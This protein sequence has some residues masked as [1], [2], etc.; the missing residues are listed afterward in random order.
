MSTSVVYGRWRRSSFIRYLSSLT[1]SALCPTFSS[2]VASS[3]RAPP[4]SSVCCCGRYARAACCRRV[5]RT[6]SRSSTQDSWTTWRRRVGRRCC[7][8]RQQQDSHSVMDGRS[9]AA[10]LCCPRPHLSPSYSRCSSSPRPKSD[11]VF[12]L[13]VGKGWEGGLKP[14]PTF[15]NPPTHC[16][17][18][19]WGG[20]SAIYTYDLDHNFG[21]TLAVAK[22]NPQVIFDISHTGLISIETT[23][24]RIRWPPF[25]I[26]S[27]YHSALRLISV[28]PFIQRERGLIKKVGGAKVAFFSD[29][30]CKFSTEEITGAAQYSILAPNSCNREDFQPKNFIFLE[31]NV[32]TKKVDKL[33]FMGEAI[34]TY[35]PPRRYWPFLQAQRWKWVSESWVMGQM[36]RHF[37]MGYIGHERWPIS[38]SA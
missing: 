7:S 22:F 4:S 27:F 33:I 37:W 25:A 23:I 21:R 2:S 36:G 19:N 5:A 31:E 13:P 9:H 32:P 24:D 16:Q 11:T 38:I 8:Q 3:S 1:S 6:S 18:M 15:F 10:K 12:E 35:S 20:G 17:F 29:R 14:S 34:A 28:C 30:W 26:V